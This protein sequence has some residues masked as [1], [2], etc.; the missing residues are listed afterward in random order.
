MMEMREVFHSNDPCMYEKIA[1]QQES[2]FPSVCHPLV[3]NPLPFASQS[4]KTKRLSKIMG[5]MN[6]RMET[7]QFFSLFRCRYGM[8]DSQ[9]SSADSAGNENSAVRTT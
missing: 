9:R 2:S 3:F 7:S 5:N 6:M 8:S 4:V 1:L